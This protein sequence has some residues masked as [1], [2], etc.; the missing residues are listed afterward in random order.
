MEGEHFNPGKFFEEVRYFYDPKT[1]DEDRMFAK[2][3]CHSKL[4]VWDPINK[5]LFNKGSPLGRHKVCYRCSALIL[6]LGCLQIGQV[7]GFFCQILELDYRANHSVRA[8]CVQVVV[9]KT[10]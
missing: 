9:K 6:K 8:D 2:A 4:D 1:K 5:V 7:V 3:I 10:L